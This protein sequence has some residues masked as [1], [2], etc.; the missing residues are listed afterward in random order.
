MGTIKVR[1]VGEGT[2]DIWVDGS[3]YGMAPINVALSPGRHTISAVPAGKEN[4]KMTRQV[5]VEAGETKDVE[6]SY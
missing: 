3:L 2:A 6:F 4:E 5:F 1:L